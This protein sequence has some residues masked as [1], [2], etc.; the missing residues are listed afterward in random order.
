MA[1]AEVAPPGGASGLQALLVGVPGLGMSPALAAALIGLFVLIALALWGLMVV[2]RQEARAKRLA[3]IVSPHRPARVLPAP[4]G[5]TRFATVSEVMVVRLA[6]LL[7]IDRRRLAEYPVPWWA[8]LLLTLPFARMVTGLGATLAGA[9][10]VW[11]TPLVWL[12]MARAVF[13]WFA[14]RRRDR[15]F[16]QFPDALATITRAVR[17]GIPVAEAMRTVAR[18]MPE[19][20][21]REFRE[22][23]DRLAVGVALNEALQET[24]QRAGLPEYRFFAAALALQAQTGGGLTETLDNLAD[25]IRKRVALRARAIALSAEARTSAWILGALPFVTLGALSLTSP[26]YVA[27]L[28]TDPT[29][30]KVLAA[31][32]GMLLMGVAVMRTMIAR[33]LS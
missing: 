11:L 5:P 21:A 8:V 29:G 31:A 20:T 10:A 25:V 27:T 19:P 18:T 24:A 14:T 2:S 6:G 7:A 32:L 1:A 15:L 3:A 17:V 9:W 16:R 30:Q 12:A 22:I 28:F 23:V 4:A 33:S 26:A 13:L